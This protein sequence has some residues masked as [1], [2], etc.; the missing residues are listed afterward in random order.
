MKEKKIDNGIKIIDESNDRKYFVVIPNCVVNGSGVYEKAMY[1][2]MKRFAGEAGVCFASIRSMAKRMEITERT[3]IRTIGKLLKRG[4]IK[5]DGTKATGGR[6]VNCYR[7]V[8][9]WEINVEKYKNKER[10]RE[11]VAH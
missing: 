11:K 10:K 4:W 3:V 5:K 1:L 9:I 7:I 8:D 6:P 2:E